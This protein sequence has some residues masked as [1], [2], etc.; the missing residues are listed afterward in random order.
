MMLARLDSAHDMQ[1]RALREQYV[2][3]SEGE[4]VIRKVIDVQLGTA[5]LRL[6]NTATGLLCDREAQISTFKTSAEYNELLFSLTMKH[7][8]IRME[9][10]TEVVAAYFRC[11]ML[12]H[13]WEGTEP[14]LHDIKD[15]VVYEI[16]EAGGLVKLQSFCNIAHEAKY[17]WAWMDSC[18]IDQTNNVELQS[19]LDSMFAWYHDSA[20]TAVYLSDVPPSST[21]GALAKSAWNTRGWTVPEFLAPKTIRFYQQ[22]WSPYLDDHSLNHKESVEIMHELEGATGID[23]RTLVSFQPG[24]RDAREKLQWASARV[25]TRP[26]DIAY[27]L[28]GIFGVRLP[29]HYGEN[30]QNALGRL[31]AGDCGSVRRHH[32]PRLGRT[33]ILRSTVVFRLTFR[34]T[35]L[36]H[37]PSHLC[38]KMKFR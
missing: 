8:H 13:R 7:T 27:S 19:S 26:E 33:T 23:A 11:V 31:P 38:L 17:H 4:D 25:T 34:H 28:F 32:R 15:K 16:K 35:Q 30:K 6:L 20:L 9:R 3:P 22:D 10:I 2:S 29:I 37:A 1:I 12:S 24:M 36:R 18:C 5:P 21:S 14:L